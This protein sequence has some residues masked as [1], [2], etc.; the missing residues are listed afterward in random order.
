MATDDYR[1][2]ADRIT[3]DLKRELTVGVRRWDGR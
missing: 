1:M 2:Y 3:E